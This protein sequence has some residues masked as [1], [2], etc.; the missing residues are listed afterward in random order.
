MSEQ[1][2]SRSEL[3]MLRRALEVYIEFWELADDDQ[4]E[5]AEQLRDQAQELA[6]VETRAA[7]SLLVAR[8]VLVAAAVVLTA[9]GLWALRS[10]T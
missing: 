9:G 10:T 7:T 4:R 3:L 6:D 8:L 1:N 2:F 5:R